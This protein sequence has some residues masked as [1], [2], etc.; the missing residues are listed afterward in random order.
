MV[1]TW[2]CPK[3]G[4]SYAPGVKECPNDGATVNDYMID[5]VTGILEDTIIER[6]DVS[7][8]EDFDVPYNRYNKVTNPVK[9]LTVRFIEE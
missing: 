5:I 7:L 3:C 4:N 8:E 2:E 6:L 9:V 1:S